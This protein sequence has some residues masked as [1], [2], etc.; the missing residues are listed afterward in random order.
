MLAKEY[1][2]QNTGYWCFAK[3][4]PDVTWSTVFKA[5]FNLLTVTSR[6][7]FWL[8][9]KTSKHKI[10]MKSLRNL[11]SRRVIKAMLDQETENTKTSNKFIFLCRARLSSRTSPKNKSRIEEASP[12]RTRRNKRSR[13][14]RGARR[15]CRKKWPF[16][17]MF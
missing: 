14:T 15:S 7:V 12:N 17:T 6:S 16:K 10:T 4:E 9:L 11:V 2:G 13:N 8:F 1:T 5:F 3:I